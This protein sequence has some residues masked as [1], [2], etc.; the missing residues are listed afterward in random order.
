[1]CK[2]ECNCEKVN[3]PHVLANL[4]DKSIGVFLLCLQ[5]AILEQTDITELFRN[6]LFQLDQDGKLEVINPPGD[7][8]IKCSDEWLEKP[9]SLN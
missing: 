6:L 2:N 7:L 4:S 1:M 8:N 5:K 9:E 3:A